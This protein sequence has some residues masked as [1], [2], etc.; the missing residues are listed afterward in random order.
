MKLRITKD[1]TT[2]QWIATSRH[3]SRTFATGTEAIA[4]AGRAIQ[5]QQRL[6]QLRRQQEERNRP[7]VLWSRFHAA[8]T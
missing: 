6:T 2:G 4:W 1:P 5:Q 7:P 3:Q 8:T